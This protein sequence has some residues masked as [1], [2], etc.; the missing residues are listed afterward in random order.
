[1]TLKSLTYKSTEPAPRG[2]SGPCPPPNY[3]FCPPSEKC[4][5]QARL[6]PRKKLTGPV[7][8]EFI[9]GPV[10]PK[11][12][13]VPPKCKQNLFPGRK[14]QVNTKTKPKIPHRRPFFWS[15]PLNLGA[16]T[17]ICTIRFHRAPPG[18]E[19]AACPPP[20]PPPP[21]PEREFR[22]TARIHGA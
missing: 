17:E 16:R 7:P 2:I 3:C 4:A 15:S 14:T 6:V 9:L 1:M 21:P 8:L 5:P 20:P 13:F 11:L 10:S 12:L 18:N 22:K 19:R